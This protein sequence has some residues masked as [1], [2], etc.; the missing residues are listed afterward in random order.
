MRIGKIWW[1]VCQKKGGVT[2]T[3]TMI[4]MISTDQM[5]STAGSLGRT[6]GISLSPVAQGLTP[7]EL[8]LT[9]KCKK[10]PN[11]HTIGFWQNVV[12][13]FRMVRY[14]KGRYSWGKVGLNQI[15]VY[16]NACSFITCHSV[17]PV[18][19]TAAALSLQRIGSESTQRYCI[20]TR[21]SRH[22]AI[23]YLTNTILRML[24]F[25]MN[26][27][28]YQSLE[29]DRVFP[30]QVLP[31]WCWGGD[32]DFCSQRR[33]QCVGHKTFYLWSVNIFCLKQNS[34]LY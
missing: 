22:I 1:M 6:P 34:Y 30:V 19:Y 11:P 3:L 16:S 7:R 24:F 12:W 25:L 33:V 21:F 20:K 2:G 10:N 28:L 14:L 29:R 23:N 18:D 8:P 9:I 26:G 5:T 13:M 32:Q 27:E 17:G 15:S 31:V 4:G